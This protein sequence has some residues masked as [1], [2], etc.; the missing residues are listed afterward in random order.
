MNPKQKQTREFFDR[1]IKNE[2]YTTGCWIL[3]GVC[4]SILVLLYFLPAQE[5]LVD[6]KESVSLLLLMVICGPSAAYF[7]ILPYHAY[8]N[9]PNHHLMSE[10]IKYHPVDR[11][12]KKKMELFYTIRYMA[13]VAGVCMFMQ[14][15]VSLFAY[16][17]ISWINIVYVLVGAFVYPVLLNALSIYFEK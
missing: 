4:T 8:G 11:V 10:L 3:L 15:F 1:L 9:Q 2:T 16:G 14:I 13:K 6:I 12:E 17:K 5:M 7:R